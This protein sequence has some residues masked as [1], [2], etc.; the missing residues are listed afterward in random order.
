MN[1]SVFLILLTVHI[2]VVVTTG[3]PVIPPPHLLRVGVDPLRPLATHTYTT[4]TKT[5]PA[6]PA[7]APVW[8]PQSVCPDSDSIPKTNPQ[9]VMECANISMPFIHTV[10]YSDPAATLHFR[11]PG[12]NSTL[13]VYSRRFLASARFTPQT[14]SKGQIWIIEGGPGGANS[15]AD[16]AGFAKY[17]FDLYST[18]HRGVGFS[19]FLWCPPQM[20]ASSPAG[21][22]LST[23]E[24]MGCVDSIRQQYGRDGLAAFTATNA[25]YDFRT[26]MQ[27]ERMHVVNPSPD[28]HVAGIGLSYGTYLL[29]RILQLDSDAHADDPGA[30][31][32]TAVF[33]GVVNPDLYNAGYQATSFTAVTRTIARECSLDTFCSSLMT[34]R[35]DV[36][37]ERLLEKMERYGHCKESGFD[38]DLLRSITSI[39]PSLLAAYTWPIVLTYRLDRCSPDDIVVLSG[40]PLTNAKLYQHLVRTSLFHAPSSVAVLFNIYFSSGIGQN[41]DPYDD[42]VQN[43]GSKVDASQLSIFRQSF[44]INFDASVWPRYTDSYDRSPWPTMLYADTLHVQG[45]LDGNTPFGYSLKAYDKYRTIPKAHPSKV[46][47]LMTEFWSGHVMQS[48]VPGALNCVAK[49]ISNANAFAGHSCLPPQ[50]V[51]FEAPPARDMQL[52]GVTNAAEYYGAVPSGGSSGPG[53]T[54][55]P[56]AD[57]VQVYDLTDNVDNVAASVHGII[58]LLIATFLCTV[59]SVYFVWRVSKQSQRRI[60]AAAS[61]NEYLAM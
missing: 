16:V 7:S 26:I 14:Q 30:V 39:A 37:M 43:V 42:L 55:I 2:C 35:P 19:T 4:A 8:Y 24:I 56:C 45:G 12:P 44:D 33:D 29:N 15:P 48:K 20:S 6:S 9:L 13:Y 60:D 61:S 25:A 17:E 51:S 10:K 47:K 40:V 31:V 59:A 34:Q 27:Y 18:D 54:S 36:V 50:H 53:A 21:N 49:F 38:A 41:W 1:V 3:F 28:Y 5:I 32:D 52:F 58:V 11:A 57:Q 23:S 22:L 46:S